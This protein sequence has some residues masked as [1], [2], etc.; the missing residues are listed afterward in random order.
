MTEATVS[1]V[2]DLLKTSK[3]ITTVDLTG[4]APELNPHFK[5]LVITARA[6]GKKS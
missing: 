5:N 6:L 4:G 2:I 3:N 1:R